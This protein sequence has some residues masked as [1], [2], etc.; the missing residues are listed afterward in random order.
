MNKKDTFKENITENVN[1]QK[2][3]IPRN[4]LDLGLLKKFQNQLNEMEDY[5]AN[6]RHLRMVR[7]G[8]RR[9]AGPLHP[10]RERPSGWHHHHGVQR[11]LL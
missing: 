5:F 9:P 10:A 6:I 3:V 7:A 11:V 2:P 1:T 8:S 4:Y